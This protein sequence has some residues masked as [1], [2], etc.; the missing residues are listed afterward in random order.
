M[1]PIWFEGMRFHGAG[2]AACF[3]LPTPDSV[4]G[5]AATPG[6]GSDVVAIVG[7]LDR[8]D[9]TP[10]EPAFLGRSAVQ[11][12]APGVP[13]GA[14]QDADVAS[15]DPR[16]TNGRD[17]RP[18]REAWPRITIVPHASGRPTEVPPVV[19]GVGRRAVGRFDTDDA[20]YRSEIGPSS[21]PAT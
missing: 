7:E 15:S 8:Q 14:D 4:I 6:I 3:D 18:P 17:D 2:A 19:E 21:A 11:F 16:G 20:A 10:R 13:V 1:A 12:E 9:V 5:Q